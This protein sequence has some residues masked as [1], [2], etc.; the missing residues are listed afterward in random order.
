VCLQR[1]FTLVEL[2]V[3][4]AI[5]GILVALLLPAVQAARE[6][7]RRTDCLNRIKQIGLATLL[8]H[9]TKKTFPSA[10][11]T[12]TE[13]A[14]PA[15][16][17]YWSYLIPVLPYMEQQALIDGIDL[18][19]FW[20]SEPNKTYLYNHQVPFLRCPSQAA[21]ESTFT[22]PPG[23]A[24]TTELSA[25]R[26]HYM[27]VMG[28]K[29]HPNCS[30]L[31]S[32][33]DPKFSY[34]VTDDCSSGGAAL[35]GVITI[36]QTDSGYT[37]GRVNVKNITDGT[38]HTF[39]IGEISWLVGPQRIWAVSTA[40]TTQPPNANWIS[41]IYTAKNIL[42]PLNFAY[43]APTD[44]TSVP[45]SPCDNNDLSFGSMHPGGA[46]FV[47]CDGSVQFI[48]EDITMD[49]L[50]ALASRRSDDS[51]QNAF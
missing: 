41:F 18:R 15:K 48:Q 50:W 4:I 3:V 8:Y 12:F 25:L 10:V 14:N 30:V 43:R 9:D 1:A 31:A 17:T 26:S 37:E 7:A 11:V 28:P 38:T 49:I 51:T 46:H 36:V 13:K 45:C 35:R 27:G 6:A 5:I 29:V 32:D 34:K 22:D 44:Y 33:K 23:G 24:T 42:S 19:A 16:L 21:A 47:M 20:N 40:T 2:L 39:L